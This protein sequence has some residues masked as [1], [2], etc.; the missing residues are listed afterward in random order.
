MQTDPIF[1]IQVFLESFTLVMLIVGLLGL[2]IPVF[3]GLIVMWFATLF[4]A[5]VEAYLGRMTIWTW[6]IFVLITIL[7]IIGNVIDNIIIAKHVLDKKVPWSSILW[8]YAAGL[9]A[10]IFATPL[11]GIVASPAGLF[12]AEY[13]RLRDR[14]QAFESTKAWMTGWGFSFAACF[15][16]GL[17]MILLWILWA[18]TYL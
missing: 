7:A 1:W 3:P 8:G 17:V 2:L 4:Y 14:K 15:G 18:W 10:S 6:L 5:I 11:I 9:V 13:Y 12:L 16:I